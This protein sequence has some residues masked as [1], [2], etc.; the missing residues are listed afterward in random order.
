MEELSD[1]VDELCNLEIIEA[2][3]A[4]L[5]I[6][7]VYNGLEQLKL[8][9]AS[10]IVLC[11]QRLSPS[12]SRESWMEYLKSVKNLI[13][14]MKFLMEKR[15]FEH[16]CSALCWS[17]YTRNELQRTLHTMD[18]LR[19]AQEKI[20]FIEVIPLIDCDF[21]KKLQCLLFFINSKIKPVSA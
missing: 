1:I 9:T 10:Y 3:H 2:T 15:S 14:S 4:C 5:G 13:D 17:S 16:G 12:K 19:M 6:I 11:E 7:D 20:Q 18:A 21:Q 8:A